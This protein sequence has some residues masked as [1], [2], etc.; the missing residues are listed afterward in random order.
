MEA[1]ELC[2]RLAETS[3]AEYDC[4][5]CGACC[6]S[7]YTGP[8]YVELA[9]AEEEARLRRL[10]LPVVM[11]PVGRPCLGTRSDGACVAFEGVAGSPSACRV[12]E[13]R[14]RQCREF[15]MGSARCRLA[16]L[17]AGLAI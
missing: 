11:N 16:R 4:R 14:P 17:Q 2:V 6:L 15:E 3:A 5:L 9:D 1:W 8:G 10:G 13:D 12:Y 7:P